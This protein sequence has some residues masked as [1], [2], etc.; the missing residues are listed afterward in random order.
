MAKI[1]E[2]PTKAY[3]LAIRRAEFPGPTRLKWEKLK[4][5]NEFTEKKRIKKLARINQGQPYNA[6]LPVPKQSN[7]LYRDALQRAPSMILMHL[8]N[9]YQLR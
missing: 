7:S 9:D 3:T 5:F 8:K 6:S 4:T 2:I 1:K